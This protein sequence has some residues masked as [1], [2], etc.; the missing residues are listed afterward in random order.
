LLCSN[1][2]PQDEHLNKIFVRSKLQYKIDQASYHMYYI[3]GSEDIFVRPHS[4]NTSPSNSNKWSQWV[5][6]STT[7]WSKGLDETTKKAME[8]ETRSLLTQGANEN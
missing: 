7:G 1:L 4:N 6:S 3:V 8:E 2:R 5:E